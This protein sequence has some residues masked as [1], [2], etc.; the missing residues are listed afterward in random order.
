MIVFCFR[1]V[2]SNVSAA[3]QDDVRRIEDAAN[4]TAT[5]R[6]GE[7]V[8]CDILEEV[9]SSFR[10]IDPGKD[11]TEGCSPDQCNTCSTSSDCTSSILSKVTQEEMDAVPQPSF[12]QSINQ[13]ELSAPVTKPSELQQQ[14]ITGRFDPKSGLPLS[15]HHSFTLRITFRA[16]VKIAFLVYMYKLISA[17]FVNNNN[18]ILDL[19]YTKGPF[20]S[21]FLRASCLTAIS[22]AASFSCVRLRNACL[23][24]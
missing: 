3:S 5:T 10:E 1:V 20:A 9:Q 17:L 6:V 8:L 21:S 19:G 4:N 11:S 13:E 24:R 12:A 2:I 7:L 23:A 22:S 18:N 16:M 14:K 15:F